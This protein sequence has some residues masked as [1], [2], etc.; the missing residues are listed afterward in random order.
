MGTDA[1]PRAKEYCLLPAGVDGIGEKIA[2]EI[3][4]S[5]SGDSDAYDNASRERL[6][7]VS[8]VGSTI[9]DVREKTYRRQNSW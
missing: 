5:F 7:Q 4:Q 6:E 9:A 2:F 8:G 1:R 3:A